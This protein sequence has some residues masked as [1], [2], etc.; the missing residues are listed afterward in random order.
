MATRL[1]VILHSMVTLAMFLRVSREFHSRWFS[2]D[3]ALLVLWNL[4]VVYL[5]VLR[6]TFSISLFCFLVPCYAKLHTIWLPSIQTSIS[7]LRNHTHDTV[8]VFDTN[9]RCYCYGIYL[10]YLAALRWTF[11]ISLFC[12]LVCG[13]QM[14]EQ[15]SRFDLT[16]DLYAMFLV[17]SF[18]IW[19]FLLKYP[20]F[21]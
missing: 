4:L 1:C 14:V 18:F 3:V 15:Y 2:I 13:D 10:C 20:N 8:I 17:C 7:L 5:A 16:R 21:G 9:P 11:S 12:F 19:R 6:W